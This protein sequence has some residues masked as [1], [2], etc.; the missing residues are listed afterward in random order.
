MDAGGVSKKGAAGVARKKTAAP[1]PAG[2][3]NEGRWP[4]VL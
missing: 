1:A 3:N 4:L 2:A